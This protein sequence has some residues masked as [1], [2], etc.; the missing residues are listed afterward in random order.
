MTAEFL[1]GPGDEP[2]TNAFPFLHPRPILRDP[3][4][5]L[6]TMSRHWIGAPWN[7]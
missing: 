2:T 6:R 4:V 7:S 5:P 3:I 1:C